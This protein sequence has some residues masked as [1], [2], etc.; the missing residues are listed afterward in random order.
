MQTS[1]AALSANHAATKLCRE[2]R[3]KKVQ[4]EAAADAA[5][6]LNVVFTAYD[7]ELER[8]E[9]FKYL[10]RLLAMDD[11]DVQ[12]IRANLKKARKCWKMLSR[13]LRAENMDARVC[14]MFYKAVVQAV[15]L[16]GSETWVLTPSAMKVLAGFHIRSAYRMARV[17]KPRKDPRTGVWTYPSTALVL[18]EVCLHT[19]EHYVQVRRQHIAAYIVDQPI[20]KLCT[21]E[22]RRRGTS[23]RT[24]WWEQPMDLELARGAAAPGVADEGD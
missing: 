9:V 17:N 19:I 16:F 7:V 8:V 10:G 23:P 15:L 11:N 20:F 6:A 24:F 12:A 1:P 3:E 13:F 5:R 2:G 14:G 21:G 22:G 18:E 4:R